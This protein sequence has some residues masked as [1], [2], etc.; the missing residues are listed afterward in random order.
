MRAL[1]TGSA[2]HL[3]EALAL[4]LTARGNE[5]VGLDRLPSAQTT[6]LGSILD[7][8][9]VDRC[10]RGVDVVFHTATLHK[11]HVASHERQ[12]FIDT[13]ITGTLTL[14]EAAAQAGV[15]S[16]IFTSTTSV[17]GDAMTPSRGEPAVWVTEALPPAPRNIYGVTKLA[18]EGI[19]R[20]ARQ[21]GGID[22]MILRT[23]R[24]FPEA[25]DDPVVRAAF[26]PG[27]V[28][29]NEFLYRRADIED[30]VSAHLA[31]ADRA[32]EVGPGPYIVSGTTP[33][34][35]GDLAGL[36]S[37]APSV[38]ARA[39]PGF[40]AVYDRRGWSMFPQIGRVYVNDKARSELGW[41]PKHSF[42]T[43]LERVAAG[44]EPM[45]ELATA[46]GAKGY[47]NDSVIAE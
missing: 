13:N 3:G 11:P 36:T 20:L 34:R 29:L 1:V 26:A 35:P 41:S 19:C 30:V 27:N 12:A 23:S 42:Q 31:A 16:L 25:D 9:L 18:A 43:M 5:V 6:Q 37:D 15:G 28:K 10:T 8:D 40:Q 17:F 4:T 47:A 2:G 32:G 24:F 44:G 46:I 33:F 7:R 14:L 38:V 21:D 22:C 45:N 39:A